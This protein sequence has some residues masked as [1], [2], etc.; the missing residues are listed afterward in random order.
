IRS[1]VDHLI[2]AFPLGI[3]TVHIKNHEKTVRVDRLLYPLVYLCIY[4]FM[5]LIELLEDV[6][7]KLLLPNLKSPRLISASIYGPVY[8]TVDIQLETGGAYKKLVDG[9]LRHA[10]G[11]R[12]FLTQPLFVV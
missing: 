10:S 8:G 12:V 1:C 4:L 6:L 7:G 11:I 2:P 9:K 5:L 3:I